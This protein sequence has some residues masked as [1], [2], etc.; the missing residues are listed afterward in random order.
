M[1]ITATEF[2]TNF[3]RYLSLARHET[4]YITKNGKRV[5]KLTDPADDQLAALA[6]FVGIASDFSDT[7]L[8]EIR[9]ERLSRQ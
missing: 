9:K 7:D 3:G 8:D 5:A 1:T 4:I 2:K 6:S